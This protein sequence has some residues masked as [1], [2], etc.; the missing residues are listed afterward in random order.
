MALNQ[1]QYASIL[2]EYDKIQTRN[3]IQLEERFKIIRS[4]IPEYEELEQ[5]IIS[6]S[7]TTSLDF[8]NEV[9]DRRNKLHDVLQDLRSQKENLLIANGYP[10][11]YLQP[12]YLCNTCQDTGLINNSKCNCFKQK[13][14]V[15]LETQSNIISSFNIHNFKTMSDVFYINQDPIHLK[16]FQHA[17]SVSKIFIKNFLNDYQNILFCGTVGTG[18]SFLSSCIA[19]ELWDQNCTILYF[20]AVTLFK[21]LKDYYFE[22]KNRPEYEYM[23][24]EFCTCDLFILDDLGTEVTTTSNVSQLFSFINERHMKQRS[25][26]ISTNYSIEEIQKVYSDRIF[27]RIIAEYE[28]CELTGQDIRLLKKLTTT[29]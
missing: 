27:S 19:K 16:N 9:E 7:I 14:I 10:A 20:D 26:I 24:H 11:N 29:N 13:E 5:R 3:R 6:T 28:L 2:L 18:K 17:V 1:E 22:Y 15:L 21:V 12:I 8:I 4:S 23:Y 25:T